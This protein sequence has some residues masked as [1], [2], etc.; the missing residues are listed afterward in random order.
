MWMTSVSLQALKPLHESPEEGGPE[1][2][3]RRS[4]WVSQAQLWEL[5]SSPSPKDSETPG[6]FPSPIGPFLIQGDTSNG[7]PP[8]QK[9]SWE[10]EAVC[11]QMVSSPRSAVTLQ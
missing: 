9:L 8:S 4:H 3:N 11:K 1:T 6:V 2:H 5:G 10:K 7:I